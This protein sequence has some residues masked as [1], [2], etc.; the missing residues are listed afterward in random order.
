MY[1]LSRFRVSQCI[2]SKT[3]MRSMSSNNANG[4]K[5]LIETHE[6]DQLL[7]EQ[8]ENLSLFNATYPIGNIVPREDHIKARIPTSVFYDHA[9]FS[10]KES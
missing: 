7:K 8:P 5:V 6:L 10:N 1:K 3:A 2:N 9:E 4:E